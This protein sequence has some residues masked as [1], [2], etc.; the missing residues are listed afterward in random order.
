M[1]KRRGSVGPGNVGI[2]VVQKSAILDSDIIASPVDEADGGKLLR[3]TSELIK[4][5]SLR[6]TRSPSRRSLFPSR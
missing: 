2:L 5:L 6:A 3:F 1:K 4:T